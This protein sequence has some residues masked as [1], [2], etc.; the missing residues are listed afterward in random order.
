MVRTGGLSLIGF[1]AWVLVTPGAAAAAQEAGAP[2]WGIAA[3]VCADGDLSS[4]GERYVA[5]LQRGARAGGWPLALQVD[6]GAG[7]ETNAVTRM[8]VAPDAGRPI[9]EAV[10]VGAQ[11]NVA[12]ANAVAAFLHWARSRVPAE[13]WALVVFGH[14]ASAAGR[15]A[16]R[17]RWN[18]GPAVAVDSSAR[19]VLTPVELA[20]GVVGGGGVDLLVLDCCFGAGVEVLWELREAAEVVVASPSRLPAAGMPWGAV[21]GTAQSTSGVTAE[22]WA[23]QCLAVAAGGDGGQATPLI[24]VRPA[25]LVTVAEA[26]QVLAETVAAEPEARVAAVALGRGLCRDWGAERELCDVRELCC[27]LGGTSDESLAE[28][29]KNTVDAID[30]CTVGHVGA[31]D[32]CG[33]VALMPGGLPRLPEGYGSRQDSFAATSGWG[34]LARLYCGRQQDLMRRT[35]DNPRRGDDA[36]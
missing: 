28:A 13:R 6:R 14:G 10:D 26:V 5:E 16:D 19:D 17:R 3:Y 9:S 31:E 34:E 1:V 24:A 23:L 35:T 32:G 30:A 33:L 7:A 29:A 15:G 18:S 20:E 36:A 8:V 11:G 4:I 27:R 12:T 25:G 22:G 21:L 2:G